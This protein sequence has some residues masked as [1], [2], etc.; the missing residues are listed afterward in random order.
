MCRKYTNTHAIMF[1]QYRSICLSLR[2]SKMEG[3]LTKILGR[4]TLTYYENEFF[5]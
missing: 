3:V 2:D 4:A 1:L 5:F